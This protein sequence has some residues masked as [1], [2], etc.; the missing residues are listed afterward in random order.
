MTSTQ[1]LTAEARRL[2][3]DAAH[4][5]AGDDEQVLVPR[6]LLIELVRHAPWHHRQEPLVLPG[7]PPRIHLN[8]EV[9][10]C[11]F[12]DEN[13][14]VD[15]AWREG[16]AAHQSDCPWIWARLLL[17]ENTYGGG[18]EDEADS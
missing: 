2:L 7:D 17:G 12:C 15:G 6:S 18:Y 11:H 4:R 5:A 13:P 1:Q 16:P 8:D 9:P 3:T 10:E 14:E